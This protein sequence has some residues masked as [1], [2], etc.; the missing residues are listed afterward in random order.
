MLEAFDAI[1]QEAENL[2][3]EESQLPKRV[4]ESL[5]RIM[6]LARYKFENSQDE[7]PEGGWE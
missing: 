3:W 4:A 6:S 5:M 7:V 2:L 1:Y